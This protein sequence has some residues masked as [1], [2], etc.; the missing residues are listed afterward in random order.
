MVHKVPRDVL[1]NQVHLENQEKMENQE[2]QAGRG[3]LACLAKMVLTVLP[4]SRV[5]PE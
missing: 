3:N 2:I 5:N 4:E 1:V